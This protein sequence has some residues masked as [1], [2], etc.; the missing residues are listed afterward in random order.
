M[1]KDEIYNQLQDAKELTKN[2]ENQL[3]EIERQEL[4]NKRIPLRELVT[5]AHKCFCP[6]NHTDGCSWSYE[7][8]DETSDTT[9]QGWAH[10]RWMEHYEHLLSTKEITLENLTIIINMVIEM[11]EKVPNLGLYL[12]RNKLAP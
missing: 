5:N 10:N 2:L 4:S 1:N 6:Y 3:K 11:K 9:W 7:G 8:S 12:F